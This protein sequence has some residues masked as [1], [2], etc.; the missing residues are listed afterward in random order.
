MVAIDLLMASGLAQAQGYPN[1]PVKIVAPFA[2][3]GLADNCLCLVGDLPPARAAGF[4]QSA[5]L[6]P[7]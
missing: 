7:S 3:G 5:R 6:A 2:A 1:R 4:G